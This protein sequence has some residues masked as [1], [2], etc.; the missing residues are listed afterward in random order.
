M[1]ERFHGVHEAFPTITAQMQRVDELTQPHSMHQ[2]MMLES[3]TLEK[4]SASVG[5]KLVQGVV[6]SQE[7]VAAINQEMRIIKW[8]F[9]R[10]CMFLAKFIYLQGILQRNVDPLVAFIA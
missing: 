10:I 3:I 8:Q 1:H 6:A 9:P 5:K 7:L 2:P 4:T